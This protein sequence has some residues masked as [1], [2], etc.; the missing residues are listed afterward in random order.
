MDSVE[1]GSCLASRSCFGVMCFTNQ[2]HS[3]GHK[4][5]AMLDASLHLLHILQGRFNLGIFQQSNIKLHS[6]GPWLRSHKDY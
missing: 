3:K 4:G 1:F 2:C 5:I 6:V